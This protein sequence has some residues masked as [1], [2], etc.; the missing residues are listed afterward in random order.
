MIYSGFALLVNQWFPW[1][2]LL[3]V[4]ST[5]FVVRILQKE[6]SLRQKVGWKK[7]GKQTYVLLPK[8]GST[9]L[10]NWYIYVFILVIPMFLWIGG[11]LEGIR[12]DMRTFIYAQHDY[13][14]LMEAKEDPLF[15]KI[16]PH[17]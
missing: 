10:V 13:D 15:K 17:Y 9:F 11:G 6:V 5:V 14:T 4:W 16:F 1:I 8:F 12:H 2:Y 7:Y 3:L